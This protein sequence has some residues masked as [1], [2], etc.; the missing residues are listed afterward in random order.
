[1][2]AATQELCSHCHLP[3][4][5]GGG[6]P[7][8]S[9]N[10]QLFCCY[11]CRIAYQ[12]GRGNSE[13]STATWLLIRLGIGAFL[14]MNIMLFS[15]LLY[16]G[17]LTEAD[18]AVRQGVHLLLWGLA[19]PV[20]I[21][22]GGPFIGDAWRAA[23]RGRITADALISIAA[24]AAY[25]YSALA[26]ATGGEDVYFDTATM[27]LVLFTLGR[28][29]EAAGR[30]RA[31]RNL[32]PLFQA[33]D[34]W[35]C[36]IAE[37]GDQRLKVRDLARGMRI[38]LR[39]GERVPVD[40]VVRHGHSETDEAVITGE[41]RPL[42]KQPGSKVIAG[43]MNLLGQLIVECTAPAVESAWAAISRSV[44][45]SLKRSTPIQR[46]ADR[47]AAFFVPGVVVLAV[48]TV[49]FWSGELPFDQSLLA[50]LAV[51]V[52]ACPCALGLAAPMATTLGIGLL[53]QRGCL[54]RDGAVLETLAQIKGVAF[55]KT[56][57]LTTGTPWLVG[58]EADDT[59][60]DAVLGVAASLE[61][62]SE[63]PIAETVV[64]AATERNISLVDV[65]EPRAVPGR[66]IVGD[67]AGKPA[68]VGTAALMNELGWKISSDLLSRAEALETGHY[69]LV[70]VGWAGRARGYLWLDDRLH[71]R[72]RE[73]VQGLR[74]QGLFT[75][76]LTGDRRSVA[77]RIFD[78]VGADAVEASLVPQDKVEALADLTR[79]HGPM[80][81][82][83]DGINDAPV[84]ASAAVGVAVGGATDLTRQTADVVLPEDGLHLMPWVIDVAVRVRRTIL[85]NL[86]GAFGYNA[87]ALTL[88]ALGWLQPV[89][90]ALLMVGSSLAVVVNSLRL[91]KQCARPMT[92][93][94]Q[95]YTLQ[96]ERGSV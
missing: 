68:A 32:E 62:G 28:Y 77:R 70:W 21:I 94:Q 4:S 59:P 45:D 85:I 37:D 27:L 16:S 82:V 91:S 34:G 60:A 9:G 18:A 7:T 35:A 6:E 14:A 75:A 58:I 56:G 73:T 57:T 38:R 33:E 11:G 5:A 86:A 74:C 2:T 71:E 30:A 39:P 23:G 81:M 84:L 10:R 66:G 63:H 41:S 78:A 40:G 3:V 47:W 93:L 65:F 20:L 61:R 69:S 92:S 67:I 64:S 15:L 44:R 31:V 12:V 50:G 22:L 13:E 55:D 25:G 90:A 26:T 43:S 29:L 76:L 48:L 96:S 49:S 72:A 87:I 88:A 79:R 42:A 8:L 53:G 80:A 89:A 36:V 54:V 51:L 19:T 1:M 24:L 83:G 95:N 46:L 52:V 17:T